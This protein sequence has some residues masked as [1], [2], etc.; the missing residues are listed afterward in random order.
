M[1][2]QSNTNSLITRMFYVSFKYIEVKEYD[3][4]VLFQRNFNSK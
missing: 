4:L 2:Q 3:K 1:D